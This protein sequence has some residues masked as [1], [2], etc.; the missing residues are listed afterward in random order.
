MAIAESV[1]HDQI[2][3]NGAFRISPFSLDAFYLLRFKG[4]PLVLADLTGVALKKLGGNADLAG[5]DPLYRMAQQWAL[6][7]FQNPAMVDGF[8]YMSRHL[9]TDKAVI[10]FNRAKPKISAKRPAKLIQASGFSAAA[11]L[12]NIVAA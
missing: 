7:V 10:L 9:N 3:I 11:A 5:H 4:T 2:P 6:A 12:F 8:I 1:L